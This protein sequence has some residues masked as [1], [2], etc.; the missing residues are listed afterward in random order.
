VF[1][2]EFFLQVKL[3]ID[4]TTV[5][6]LVLPC[7]LLMTGDV[8]SESRS[9]MG[10]GSRRCRMAAWDKPI[11]GWGGVHKE[12]FQI[13]V[14]MV[15]RG[16]RRPSCVVYVTQE[17]LI[18]IKQTLAYLAVGIVRGESVRRCCGGRKGGGFFLVTFVC[19]FVCKTATPLTP[20]RR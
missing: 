14:G 9:R 18:F 1:G 15:V 20:P 17:C 16:G 12:H 13:P 4:K 2:V 3:L 7:W 11:K 10:E 6:V 19:L 5:R 8:Q